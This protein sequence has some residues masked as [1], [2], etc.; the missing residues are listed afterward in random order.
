MNVLWIFIAVINN[1]YNKMWGKFIFDMKKMCLQKFLNCTNS[2]NVCKLITSV[3]IILY[4]AGLVYYQLHSNNDTYTQVPYDKIPS[5]NIS[6]YSNDIF[7]ILS[8]CMLLHTAQVRALGKNMC[9]KL[10]AILVLSAS[11]YLTINFYQNY[12]NAFLIPKI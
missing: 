1:C 8:L 4:Y 2:I 5:N 9:S 10:T 12:G 11:I 6:Q 7:Q 3:L